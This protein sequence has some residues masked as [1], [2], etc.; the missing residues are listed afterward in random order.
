MLVL[1]A[2]HQGL[3]ADLV[4]E[5]EERADHVAAEGADQSFHCGLK[6]VE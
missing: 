4:R 5:V 3:H 6:L 1:D 2:L